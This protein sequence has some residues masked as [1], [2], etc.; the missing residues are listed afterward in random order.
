MHRHHFC[1]QLPG[2]YI[3]GHLQTEAAAMKNAVHQDPQAIGTIR[4]D[5]TE[6][7]ETYKFKILLTVDPKTQMTNKLGLGVDLK[8][9][10][11]ET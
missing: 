8:D 3:E 2:T 4:E 11:L 7:Q 9:A 6:Q 5:R 10:K 1:I